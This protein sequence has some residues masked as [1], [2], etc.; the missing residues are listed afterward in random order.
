MLKGEQD[1]YNKKE[2]FTD[3]LELELRI[4]VAMDMSILQ[5]YLHQLLVNSAGSQP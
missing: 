3:L 1:S 4:I 2:Y 5:T